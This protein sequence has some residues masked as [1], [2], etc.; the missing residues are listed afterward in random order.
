MADPAVTEIVDAVRSDVRAKL[1]DLLDEVAG[2]KVL[3]LDSTIVGPLDLIVSPSDLK[4]HGVQNWYK[5]SETAV[6][7]DCSQMI[8]LV[9]CARV[10]LIDMIAAQILADEA[11]GKDRMYVVVFVPRKTEQCVERLGRSSVRANVRIAECAVHY[12][13]FD[14]DILSMEIP[15]VFHDF[16]VLG[17]PSGPF[18]AAKALMSLQSLVGTIPSVH[19]IGGAAKTLVDVMLR[20]RK[21]EQ[22]S[23]ALKEPKPLREQELCQAGVPPV[24]P[25]RNGA[26]ASRRRE[27]A[28]SQAKSQPASL[29]PQPQEGARKA[30]G[31][32]KISE[33]VVIDR[34]VDL[35]SVLC[36][37]FTYQA[38]IDMSLGVQNNST[39]I[40]SASWAKD[41]STVRLS[42]DDPFYQEI[43]DLHIDRLGPLL[44]EKARAIQKTYSE[45]DNVKSP[46][47]MAE[48]IKKFKTAQSAHPVVEIHINLAHDLKDAIQ[49]EDYKQL[50]KL[51]DDITAQ[52]TASQSCLDSIEDL[53]DDQKP[54]HEALRLL[55]LYSLVNNGIK[56]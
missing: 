9:R 48:Y 31:G 37:Q 20:L 49:T 27:G 13:P 40:S 34:R 11:E 55:C 16:H 42:P 10:E 19:A 41:R 33:V 24:A 28:T 5:L 22:V 7:S 38:L 52:S 30:Q 45:K 39:D 54:I 51:E 47:E 8:F 23:Q 17:D 44:Q 26:A 12:F 46:N 2:R 53:M 4:D 43:R 21:E 18:Y 32:P 36:S 3:M 56:A 25:L 1:L 35:F 14:K 15:G 50:L 6:S 29:Q